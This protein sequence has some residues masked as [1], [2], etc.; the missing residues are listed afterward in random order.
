M[1]KIIT[2]AISILVTFRSL[3]M[4][5]LLIWRKISW[6]SFF[7][8]RPGRLLLADVLDTL[9]LL[10]WLRRSTATDPASIHECQSDLNSSFNLLPFLEFSF[11]WLLWLWILECSVL[12]LFLFMTEEPW[13][14]FVFESKLLFEGSCFAFFEALVDFKD[15]SNRDLCFGKL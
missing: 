11:P 12:A 13:P 15:K 8:P 1:A 6:H 9:F 14:A 10:F 7:C 5:V 3:T 4:E 2:K